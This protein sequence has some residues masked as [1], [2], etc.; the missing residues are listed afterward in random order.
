MTGKM[1]RREIG[2][3]AWVFVACG[4]EK[5]FRSLEIA[6]ALLKKHSSLPVVLVT[7]RA[8]NQVQPPPCVV[9]DT[10][11]PRE[12]THRQAAIFLKTSLNRILPPGRTYC[13]LDTD[14]LAVRPGPDK[15]FELLGNR[16]ILFAPDHCT[17]EMFSPR[18]VR[19]GCARAY[20]EREE[21]FNRLMEKHMGPP[22]ADPVLADRKNRLERLI[23]EFK[24]NQII[25][26]LELSR[27]RSRLDL[28]NQNI[29]KRKRSA[30]Q[31]ILPS[32]AGRVADWFKPSPR[33]LFE[34]EGFYWDAK[35]HRC[36]DRDGNVLF[37]RE[38][39][40]L[41]HFFRTNG[42][43]TFDWQ[44]RRWYDWEGNLLFDDLRW[45]EFVRA[46]EK[47]HGYAR[48]PGT[49]QWLDPAGNPEFDCQC[50]HLSQ[51]LGE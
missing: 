4:G 32:L 43:Y 11:A 30:P 51:A 1:E 21:R 27:K 19:C 5:H 14:V 50:G 34:R 20:E 47:A 49:G 46:L 24:K 22:L 18:A 39:H 45:R 6:L 40:D 31:G 12:M 35:S 26:T 28:L 38:F 7:D 42:G 2:D 16:P 25:S 44:K 13:Y 48:G 8:R 17:L 9:M 29:Q 15:I 37:D 10:P 23:L 3:R 41:D 36:S 33:T